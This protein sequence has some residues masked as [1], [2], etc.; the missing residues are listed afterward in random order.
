M[1]KLM[2]LWTVL[3]FLFVIVE[4]ASAVDLT[5]I[6]QD[7]SLYEEGFILERKDVYPTPGAFV[8][9]GRVAQDVVTYTDSTV[10]V[11]WTYTYRVSAFNVAGVSVPS[12]EDSGPKLGPSDAPTGFAVTVLVTVI[13]Q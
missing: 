11:G 6:W 12:N 1:K 9:L 4:V 8:E 3:F 2:V 13:V 10:Q 5:M 7:N